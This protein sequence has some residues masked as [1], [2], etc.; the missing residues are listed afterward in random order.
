MNWT[1][2]TSIAIPGFMEANELQWL[3]DRASESRLVLEVG[4]WLGRSTSAL[5][6]G[7]PGRVYTVDTWEGSPSEINGAHAEALT[8]DLF[9]EA[10]K[11]LLPWPNIN[12]MKMTSLQASRMV[13]PG[14]IDM[15]FIDGEH[16]REAVLIDL[17]AWHPKCRKLLCGHDSGFDGVLGALS[18]FGI[19]YQPGPGSLWFM[20]ILQ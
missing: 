18:I 16:T 9:N 2:E 1:P 20:E 13:K 11:Y 7:C 8:K 3:H 14:S 15:I 19:P 17:L 4:C 5:A 10:Q 6:A 12:F